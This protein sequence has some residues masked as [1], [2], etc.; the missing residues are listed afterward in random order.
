MTNLLFHQISFLQKDESC[1]TVLFIYQHNSE[2]Q[3]CV[4]EMEDESLHIVKWE[5]DCEQ[6]KDHL[7]LIK[8]KEKEFDEFMEAKGF[9]YF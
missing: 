2:G 6:T 1:T 7:D 5:N 9:S 8:S 3:V 4:T